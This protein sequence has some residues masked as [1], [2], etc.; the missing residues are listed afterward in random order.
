MLKL[1]LPLLEKVVELATPNIIPEIC[2]I[3]QR[4]VWSQAIRGH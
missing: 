2:V 3:E 1:N 4:Q